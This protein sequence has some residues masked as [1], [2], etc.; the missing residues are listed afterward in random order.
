MSDSVFIGRKNELERLGSLY[1]RGR[2][3]LVVVKGRRRIGKS[4]LILEFAKKTFPQ[5]FWGFAGLAPQ[6]GMSSQEQRDHFAQQ[7][8]LFL[9]VPVMNFQDWSEAF[10]YLS[11]HIQ[12]GD[13]ILFDEISW[14][15]SKDPT[16]IPKLKAWWDKQS[17]HMLLVFCGSV[18]TWI[19]KNILKSTAFLVG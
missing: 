10:E 14:M 5:T 17:I 19:E 6:E 12:S 18:S 9:K 11:L 4:R 7:L 1:Q 15:G 2:S 16:F 8:A 3:G 13:I